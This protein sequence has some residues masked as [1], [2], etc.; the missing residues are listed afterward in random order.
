MSSS[1]LPGARRGGRRARVRVATL[2]ILLLVLLPVPLPAPDGVAA[3]A[4]GGAAR[5]GGSGPVDVLYAGSL[6][7]LVRG[8]VAPAFHAATG[9]TLTGVA[10]GSKALAADIGGG[11]QRADVFV[12]AAPSVDRSLEGRAGGGWVSWYAT[13]AS[14]P[15]VLA[16]DR[17]SPFAA[18]L[19]RR[20][21]YR[22]VTEPG[23][24]LG[25]TDPTV[26]PKGALAVTALD[27]AA[28]TEHDPALRS[29]TSSTAGVFPEQ[30]LVGRLQSGQLDAGFFYGVE[31]AAAR[32]PTVPLAGVHLAGR[33]TVTVVNRAPH[34]AAA[35][36]LVA[37]LL[38]RHGRKTM[39]KNG[40]VPVVPPRLSGDRAAVPPSLRKVL[41]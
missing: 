31:A 35:R 21:W 25:R 3:A 12:S 29:L 18:Q 17:R 1:W 32:L 20:P 40:L 19:R 38:G 22:V 7:T 36:A 15:L 41:R 23:F 34:P 9:Y 11:L 26:D 30:T 8:D 13:F 5:P 14:S 33:Y 28:R 39:K 10:A 24:R 2:G 16:Y 27:R 4:G 6:L 37:W